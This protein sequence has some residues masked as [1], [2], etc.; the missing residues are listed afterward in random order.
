MLIASFPKFVIEKSQNIVVFLMPC[1]QK[2]QSF[3]LRSSSMKSLQLKC[4]IETR[5]MV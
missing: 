5:H 1:D 4:A 3:D 2:M